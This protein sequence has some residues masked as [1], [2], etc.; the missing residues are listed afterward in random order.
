M[1]ANNGVPANFGPSFARH[2]TYD[3]SFSRNSESCI[4]KIALPPS[5]RHLH[6]PSERSRRGSRHQ[7]AT[8]GN[9]PDSPATSE[10]VVH[11]IRA[12]RLSSEAHAAVQELTRHHLTP[13][14]C[15]V[16][17]QG[18]FGDTFPI[19]EGK[20]GNRFCTR[21]S[22]SATIHCRCACESEARLRERSAI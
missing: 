17:T 14:V 15:R 1:T 19:P 18:A 13:A 5:H 7:R 21:G 10:S 9:S 16:R 22:P 6:S 12:D 8:P 2:P 3:I 4:E 20:E 11:N